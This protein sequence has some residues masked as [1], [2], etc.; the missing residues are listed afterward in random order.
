MPIVTSFNPNGRQEIKQAISYPDYAL[1]KA[2]L[3]HVMQRDH[4][5]GLDGKYLI[6]STYFDNFANKVLNEKKEGFINRDKYRVRI[7]GKSNNV[8]NLERKSKRNN[9]TFKTKCSISQ[10][11]YEKLRIGEIAW[12]E[13]DDRALIRDLYHEMN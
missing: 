11:E 13:N 3:Q 4:H 12:M 6:R 8:I 5:A 10:A 1:L 2:K 7:Y 9:V